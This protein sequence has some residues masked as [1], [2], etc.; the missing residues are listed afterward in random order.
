[1]NGNEELL[2]TGSHD[3]EGYHATENGSPEEKPYTL[4]SEFKFTLNSS[5]PLIVSFF[6]QYLLSVTTIFACGKLGAKELAASSLAVCTFNITGLAIFQGMAT[7][8]DSFCSQ[9]YG[10]GDLLNVGVYFQRCSLMIAVATVPLCFIWWYSGAL[11]KPMLGDAELAE[12]TQLYLRVNTLGTPGLFLFETGKRFLQAQN[13]FNATTYILLIVV[14]IN[15]VLNY[16]LVW[17]PTYG[18][19]YI[20]APIAV[21]IIYWL[22]ALLMLFYVIFI[23][24]KKCWN[25]LDFQKAIINWCPMLKLALPGVIM[26]EAEYLAFEVLTI[27]A[28]SFGT[29]AIAAQSITSNIGNLAF[30]LGFAIAVAL[31]TRIGHFVGMQNIY[32]AKLV[33]K[34]VIA[35]SAGLSLFNFSVMFLLRGPLA[36]L[37]TSSPSVIVIAKKLLLLAAINQ[38]CDS[39]NVLC[40]GVLRGQGRQKVGSILNMVSYYVIAL[41]I[42]YILAYPLNFGAEGLW[43]GLILGVAFLAISEAILIYRSDWDSIILESLTRHDH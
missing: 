25:G 5:A 31:T 29:D 43:V 33:L 30:Q 41:P 3:A 17:N 6:L 10:S 34:V 23:D 37:F 18:L 32:G 11:L 39:L 26:V 21:S 42:G 22:S 40:A 27:L 4:K 2:L 20:G 38:I 14:P 9:A 7:S 16:L 15:M 24:G 36:K 12:M 28:A 19:G 13:I 8:L 35:L 1:M